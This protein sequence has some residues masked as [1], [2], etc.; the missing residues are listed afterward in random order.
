[1]CEPT[2]DQPSSLACVCVPSPQP[3]SATYSDGEAPGSASEMAPTVPLNAWPSVAEIAFP[4][5]VNGGSVLTTAPGPVGWIPAGGPQI[6]LDASLH[7]LTPCG[8]GVPAGVPSGTLISSVPI[9]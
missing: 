8:N 5:T 3:M 7:Q 2:T 4:V 9:I 6:A 1:M